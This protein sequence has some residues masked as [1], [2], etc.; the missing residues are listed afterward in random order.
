MGSSQGPNTVTSGADDATIGIYTWSNPGNITLEDGSI[1]TATILGT[2]SGS[3]THYIKGLAPGFTIPSDAVIDGINPEFKRYST[4]GS[5][6]MGET[7]ISLVRAGVIET[8]NRAVA[9]N[10]SSGL[11]W[12][13]YGG[14][15]DLWGA[16][17]T[18]AD[19]NN[20]GFGVV[21]DAYWSG[22]PTSTANVD[23]IR[24]TVF[25]HTAAGPA[26]QSIE[27]EEVY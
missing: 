15:T 24:I 11:R 12:D 7:R 5:G 22:I 8:T 10:W 25:Y 4:G 1:A 17:W 6:G 18:P 13:S 27:L 21:M 26:S 9:L 23:A 19:I 14:P 2:G 3:N 20:A 16:A